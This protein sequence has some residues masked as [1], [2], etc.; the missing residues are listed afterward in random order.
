[1]REDGGVIYAGGRWSHIC[2]ITGRWFFR[3]GCFF[4]WSHICG[5]TG[6]WFFRQGDYRTVESYMREDGGVIYAGG[7]W[8][9]RQGDYRTVVL[10]SRG[11]QDGGVFFVVYVCSFVLLHYMYTL[12]KSLNRERTHRQLACF[13][14]SINLC[15]IYLYL[16]L[17][18]NDI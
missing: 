18:D 3:Q 11:L 1:M 15:A 12:D 17:N 16:C 10:S 2:G 4:R 8:F 7:R 5:I 13:I 6:R 9:F 14:A